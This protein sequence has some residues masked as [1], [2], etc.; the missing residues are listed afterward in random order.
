[1]EIPAWQLS[2]SSRE[3]AFCGQLFLG[4]AENPEITGK[5]LKKITLR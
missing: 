3:I 4:Q 5:S 2:A 1:M